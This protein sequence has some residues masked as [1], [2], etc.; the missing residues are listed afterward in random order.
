MFTHLQLIKAAFVAVLE[1][2][3]VG[4]TWPQRDREKFEL[5]SKSEIYKQKLRRILKKKT[6]GKE[7]CVLKR[8][9]RVMK[10]SAW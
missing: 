9:V 2:R 7:K 8:E 3:S 10:R 4:S 5:R 1:T 6:C